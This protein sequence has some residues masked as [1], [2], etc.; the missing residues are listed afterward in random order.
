MLGVQYFLAKAFPTIAPIIE[1]I[2]FA[3]PVIANSVC[4]TS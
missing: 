2:E 1:G 4:Y 3:I